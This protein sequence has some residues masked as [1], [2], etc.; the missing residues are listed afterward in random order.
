MAVICHDTLVQIAVAHRAVRLLHR[1][2]QDLL[3]ML[4]GALNMSRLL[5]DVL[6]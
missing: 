2:E 1:V 5:H 3:A 4:A 6:L